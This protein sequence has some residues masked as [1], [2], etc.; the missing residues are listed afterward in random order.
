[1]FIAYLEVEIR[2]FFNHFYCSCLSSTSCI[3]RYFPCT[4]NI[5]TNERFISSFITQKLNS[6]TLRI[7][8]VPLINYG[9]DSRFRISINQMAF[10]KVKKNGS[11]VAADHFFLLKLDEIENREKKQTICYVIK[12]RLM[13]TLTRHLQC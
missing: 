12:A 1:M 11:S 2:R 9:T 3:F 5:F 6:R 4:G 7:F 13:I 8:D 10:C